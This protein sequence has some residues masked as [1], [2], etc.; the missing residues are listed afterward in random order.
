MKWYSSMSSGPVTKPWWRRST[1]SCSPDELTAIITA[2]SGGYYQLPTDPYN[3]V[4]DS[5]YVGDGT[6]A[7]CLNVLKRIGITHVVNAACGKDKTLNLINTS[8]EYYRDAKIKFLGIEAYDM[9]GFHLYPYFEES[10]IFIHDAIQNGGKVYIHCRQGIS[11]SATIALAYLILKQD[12]SAQEAVRIVRQRREVIP[13]DGFLKQ[14]CQLNELVRANK[15]NS[16]K[17]SQAP[18]SSSSEY[19]R[20]VRVV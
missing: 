1:P 9:I 5:I 11:R 20:Q 8:A 19:T 2:P 6:T 16:S 14:L 15:L 7:L 17:D 10:A 18:S 4:Y 3:E 13:N 12:L